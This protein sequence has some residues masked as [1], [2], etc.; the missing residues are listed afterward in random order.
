MDTF[1]LVASLGL[2]ACRCER[3][4][5]SGH[6]VQREKSQDQTSF[7]GQD[8]DV[9]EGESEIEAG[10]QEPGGSVIKCN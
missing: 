4:M 3:Q 10:F 8:D 2:P 7:P 5:A 9:G 6:G 1:R